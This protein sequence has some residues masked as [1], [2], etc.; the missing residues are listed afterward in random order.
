[1]TVLVTGSRTWNSWAQLTIKLD[2][3]KER[4]FTKLIHGGARGADY[5]A[6][7][8]GHALGYAV[9]AYPADWSKGKGAG[10]A[11][12]QQMLET[13]PDLVLACFMARRTPGTSDMVRRAKGAGVPVEELWDGVSG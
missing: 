11:R 8:V 3:L 10:F 5:I 7:E 12:N 9:T 4:G 6:G 13:K 1:M 2:V